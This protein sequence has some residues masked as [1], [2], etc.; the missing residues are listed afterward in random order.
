MTDS[1]ISRWKKATLVPTFLA[2]EDKKRLR[3]VSRL[4]VKAMDELN[5]E[6]TK[7][8][9]FGVT[10]ACREIIFDCKDGIPV[11][12]CIMHAFDTDHMSIKIEHTLDI[13]H[14]KEQS[15]EDIDESVCNTLAMASA[16]DV[17]VFPNTSS[18]APLLKKYHHKMLTDGFTAPDGKGGKQRLRLTKSIASRVDSADLFNKIDPTE[19]I[20]PADLL[21]ISEAIHQELDSLVGV[22]I[23]IDGMR[24]AISELSDLLNASER[25]E[26]AVQAC[27][28]ANP[29]LFGADYRQII[30]KHRFGAEFELDYALVRHSGIIDLIEIESP[31]LPLFNAKGD[32]SSHLVHAEQQVADWLA[33]A[34]ANNPYAQKALPGLTAPI[35]YVVI[36]R[37]TTLTQRT[38]S[39]LKAR[40]AM[41]RGQV[42]ILTYDDL[43]ERS[44]SILSAVSAIGYSRRES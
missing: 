10:Q 33:W 22:R 14:D 4:Q 43:I 26:N 16:L 17:P 5:S 36:G 27:L 32:P 40:N 42:Q 12:H 11:F 1:R 19:A 38:R 39:R 37:S 28:T 35:G 29:I 20:S 34:E 44:Q 24:Q 30:P 6:E 41:F 21:L 15:Q 18:V 9:N 13:I 3:S 2:G 25:N 7:L 23:F 8:T 31:S